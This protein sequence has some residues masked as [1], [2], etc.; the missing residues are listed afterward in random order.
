MNSFP[1]ISRIL[2]P[3]LG[4]ALLGLGAGCA[5]FGFPRSHD[6]AVDAIT[7][8]PGAGGTS[9]QFGARTAPRDASQHGRALACV[10]AALANKG[11]YEAPP[12]AVADMIITVDYGIG[13]RIP[14]LNGPPEL[15]KYLHLSARKIIGGDAL[16]T[17]ELWN[18]RVTTTA[19]DLNLETSLPL[20]AAVA[21]DYVGVD[22]Q[23]EK[24][25]SIPGDSVAVAKIAEIM[26]PA[27]K[28]P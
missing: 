3:C 1:R 27:P 25:V 4:A 2:V 11:M 13:N 21:A 22:T 20:L 17:E 24:T 14:V 9:F 15:E 12:K 23:S 5:D 8:Q 28:S 19:A 6:V 10:E 18:V 7:A 26:R 16:K